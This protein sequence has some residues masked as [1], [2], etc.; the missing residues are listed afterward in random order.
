MAKVDM[1]SGEVAA[2]FV[3]ALVPAPPARLFRPQTSTLEACPEP[4]LKVGL[5][6]SIAVGIIIVNGVSGVGS[7]LS[8][9]VNKIDDLTNLAQKVK[10]I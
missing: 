4:M 8:Q 5:T 3:G 10:K 1:A 7:S 6:G 2:R 9:K